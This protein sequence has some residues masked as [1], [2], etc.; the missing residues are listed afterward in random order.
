VAALVGS[1]AG[2]LAGRGV[3]SWLSIHGFGQS[4]GSSVAVGVGVG[5]LAVLVMVGVTVAID[6]SALTRVRR[7]RPD[8]ETADVV[9]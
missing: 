2:A 8:P 6:P 5:V 1:A 9:A 3:A 7:R 4:L